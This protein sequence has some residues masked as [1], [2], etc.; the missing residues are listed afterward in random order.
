MRRWWWLG[1][2]LGSR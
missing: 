1:Q 2:A